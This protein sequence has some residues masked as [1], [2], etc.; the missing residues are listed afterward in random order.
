M[1]NPKG[2]RYEREVMDHFREKGFDA[3]RLRLTGK[4]DEGDIAVRV[5]PNWRLILEAKNRKGMNLAG[6]IGEAEV[7][8]E[9]YA[10]SRGLDLANVGFAVVHK[11]PGKGVAHSYVTIPLYEYLEQLR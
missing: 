11:R 7:E 10:K 5:M 3:E 9:N 6:W 2:S 4:L 1:G 8:R